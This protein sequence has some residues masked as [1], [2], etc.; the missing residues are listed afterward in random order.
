M[1]S[2]INSEII[3]FGIYA[4]AGIIMMW[5]EKDG[6][7][8]GLAI[9]VFLGALAM[10]LVLLHERY[11]LLHRIPVISYC[12][13]I[14]DSDG[15]RYILVD[16]TLR[17]IGGYDTPFYSVKKAEQ[18]ISREDKCEHCGAVL[19]EHFDVSDHMTPQER[20]ARIEKQVDYLT[21]PL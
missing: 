18:L 17:C 20:H 2:E 11:R 10:S 7:M 3:N 15:C 9:A 8:K 16:S 19:I 12:T 4:L 6:I 14:Q 1:Y 21:A 13:H 5:N